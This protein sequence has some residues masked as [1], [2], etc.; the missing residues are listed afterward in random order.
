[1]KIIN[2]EQNSPE[3]F[4]AK[5]GI[6]SASNFDK[7]ITIEEKPSKQRTR[8]LYQLAGERITGVS[9][10]NGYTNEDI[11][12]GKQLE[13]E[14]RNLYTFTT[15]RK[16]E[17]VG[18]CLTDDSKFGASPDGLVGKEGLLEIKC[19]K[20]STHVGYLANGIMP[21]DYVQQVQGQLL[22]TDRKWVDFVSYFPG[23]KPFIVRC[24]RNEKFLEVLKNE[25][26]KFCEE[27]DALVEDIK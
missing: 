1:M 10:Q 3:W 21:L 8:Y 13:E 2:C 12:R 6:P 15:G 11:E 17:L 26:D 7:L 20:L 25:L 27:L 5:A 16:G 9:E 18:F 14:A 4:K 22:V 19:P 24:P 23:V